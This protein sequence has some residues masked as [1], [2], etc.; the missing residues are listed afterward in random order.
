MEPLEPRWRHPLQS[1]PVRLHDLRH[2]A[3]TLSLAVG[4]HMKAIQ[5]LLATPTR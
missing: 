4:L 2:C 1:A 5:T 3:V